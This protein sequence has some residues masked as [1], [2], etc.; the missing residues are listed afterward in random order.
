MRKRRVFLCVWGGGLTKK[1]GWGGRCYFYD[2]GTV[3]SGKVWFHRNKSVI[4]EGG[5][6]GERTRKNYFRPTFSAH[7]TVQLFSF[8]LTL[9]FCRTVYKSRVLETSK[10]YFRKKSNL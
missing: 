10:K 4:L 9:G 1:L 2:L 5:G 6:S 3:S 7:L 8:F